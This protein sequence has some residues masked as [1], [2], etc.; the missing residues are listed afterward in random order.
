MTA[1]TINLATAIASIILAVIAFAQA[2]YFYTQTKNT[3]SRVETTLSAINAQVQTLQSING[4]TLDRLTKYVTTPKDDGTSQATQALSSATQQFTTLLQSL[5]LPT[6][7]TNDAALRNELVVTYIALWYYS[8]TTNIWASFSLP[9]VH[10]FDN[11]V[12]YHALV[13][14]VIDRS[15]ADFQLMSS[16]V[17]QLTDVQ[18]KAS[19]ISHLYDEVKDVF[20]PLVCDT[21]QH[22]ANKSQP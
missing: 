17:N 22:F 13:K 20:Q 16:L 3:E 6:I 11:T 19:T 15:F 10:E 7:S 12:P 18:I 5:Q 21:A 9:T 1:D 8:A 2:I 4:K 14:Q